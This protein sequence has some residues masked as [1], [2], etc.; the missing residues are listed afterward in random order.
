MSAG[1]IVFVRDRARTR[2]AAAAAATALVLATGACGSDSATGPGNPDS[3]ATDY[4][5]A[6]A[7]AP[8][9]LADLYEQANRILPGGLPAYE[10]RIAGLEGYPVVVNKWASWC[11]PCRAEF[12]FFQKLAAERG[13]EIAFLGIDAQDADDAAATFLSELPVPY[14]SYS[15]PDLEISKE[16]DVEREFP[17]TIFYDASGEIA[18]VHRGGY[19]EQADLEADIDRYAR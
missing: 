16:L 5:Q 11:G 6:L 14:P 19:Q 3:A 4:E 2:I 1:M 7:D 8:A 18:Y 15:D 10:E 12:P 9:P 17:S 13:E